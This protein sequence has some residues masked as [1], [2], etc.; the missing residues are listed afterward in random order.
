MCMKCDTLKGYALFMSHMV[1][2]LWS[3]VVSENNLLQ[4]IML[5]KGNRVM[6][7]L[8]TIKHEC[9]DRDEWC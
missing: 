8:R 3:Y 2:K 4:Y 5:F 9:M 1:Y 6:A 7:H